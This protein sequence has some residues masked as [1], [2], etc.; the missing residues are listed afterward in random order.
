MKHFLLFAFLIITCRGALSA[1]WYEG[2]WVY[3]SHLT[4]RHNPDI[5]TEGMR[6]V[7]AAFDKWAGQVEVTPKRV[8]GKASQMG[9]PYRLAGRSSSHVLLEVKGG[10][11]DLVK[12]F[13]PDLRNK[14]LRCRIVRISPKVVAFDVPELQTIQM[15][16]KR[17][18]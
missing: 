6:E 5:H 10:A 14:S 1:E 18:K 13:N 2:V 7:K 3:D 17:V 9:V 15:Y 12:A 16:L 4:E 8:K 11:V